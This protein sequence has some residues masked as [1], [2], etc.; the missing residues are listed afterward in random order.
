MPKSGEASAT[1]LLHHLPVDAQAT[2]SLRRVVHQRAIFA[3]LFAVAQL[4]TSLE[5][6]LAQACRVAAEAC[7]APFAKVLEHR[8]EQGDFL[9]VAGVGWHPGVVGGARAAGDPSNPA[10]E[11]FTTGRPVS[12]SDVRQ[13]RDYHLPAIYSDHGIISTSNVPIIGA[14]DVY[15]V[16]EVDRQ[17]HR[18]FDLL[19]TSFLASVAGIVADARERIRRE[20]D[21]QAAHDARAVLLRE[22]HH[23]VRN[24][25]QAL[26]AR[27]HRHAQDAGTGRSRQRLEDVERRVFALASLYDHLVVTPPEEERLDLSRYLEDLCDRMRDFYGTSERG[28]ALVCHVESGIVLDIGVCTA[29]GTVANELVANA[30]EYA[31]GALGG[32]IE[33][34]LARNARGL[35]LSIA[36]NGAGMGRPRP[37]SIGLSLVD[38]LI[39]SIGGS[40]AMSSDA[41]T[42]WTIELPG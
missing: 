34:A 36:D 3:E 29:L 7:D 26:L 40:I 15:G 6:L 2:V 18:P 5:P 20:A 8:P 16:L 9:V 35:A 1:A 28:I 23:R 4:E 19:D 32:T 30:V 27:L 33:I 12:V 39:D 17:D 13:R 22:H 24:S 37:E 10:G 31:F 14:S 11:A 25:Y 41:G 42:R 38:R 21:L